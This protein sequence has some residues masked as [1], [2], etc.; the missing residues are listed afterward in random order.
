MQDVGKRQFPLE[1]VGWPDY[2]DMDGTF[3]HQDWGRER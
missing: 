3:E 1:T 2:V